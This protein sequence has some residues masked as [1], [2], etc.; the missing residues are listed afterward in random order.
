MAS[1]EAEAACL[2]YAWREIWA[3]PNQLATIGGEWR[4]WIWLAGRGFGKTR[5]VAEWAREMAW[6]RPGSTGMMAAATSN[7]MTSVLLG[8]TSGILK[9]SPPWF[10]PK[11][12]ASR[13]HGERLV[14]PN[15]ST[16]FVRSADEPGRMR[17]PGFNWAA[18]DELAAWRSKRG[19]HAFDMLDMGLREP[20]GPDKLAP[21]CVIATTPKPGNPHL[22]RIIN[23]P[24]TV[25]VGGSMMDNAENLDPVFIESMLETYE[26]TDLGR[27]EIYG[28]LLTEREG[29]LW[30]R[31]ML[32]DHRV[33]AAPH[34][35]QVYVGVDPAVSSGAKADE[36]GIVTVGKSGRD[37]Y[38]LAD[39][40]GRMS[41]NA[42]GD[43][44]VQVY[45]DRQ[46]DRIIG[47]KNNGG[48]LIEIMLRQK[49]RGI[50][51]RGVNAS[52]GKTPRAE[53]VS[54]LSEQGRLHIVGSMPQLE[55]Q[56]TS[57]VAG[58]TTIKC[59][60]RMDALVWAVT[61]LNKPRGGFGVIN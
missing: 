59:P 29:A 13:D 35:E 37:F 39:D 1:I 42:W 22:E 10:M 47:E 30:T 55:A 27:Q 52:R 56:L 61:V 57:W 40:S 18:I 21:Q 41:P 11:H 7:D 28:E 54:A 23:N 24:L 4:Y 48:D 15:G 31:A 46:A 19:E 60:D 8:G 6:S 43:K 32:D 53:P 34:C 58:D 3:R 2:H 45:H 51:Y 17:G 44:V 49:D 12:T 16:A 5:C 33:P 20:Y 36:T 9:I 14:W 25:H 38:V 26:N 50:S